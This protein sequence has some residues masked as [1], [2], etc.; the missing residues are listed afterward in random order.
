[1]LSMGDHSRSLK[2][3]IRRVPLR[4]SAE[5]CINLSPKMK[6][7][8]VS[9]RAPQPL[10]LCP[11]AVPRG[12]GVLNWGGGGCSVAAMLVPLPQRGLRIQQSSADQRPDAL[13]PSGLAQCR[14]AG[15]D[16][17]ASLRP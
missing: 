1:M 14:A 11:W 2:S 17:R 6:A 13:G 3:G 16:G 5:M 10:L 12:L 9:L 15:A 7:S 4:F 8:A